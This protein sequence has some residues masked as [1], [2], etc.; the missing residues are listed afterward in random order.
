MA[1][2]E[3]QLEQA[4]L[5]AGLVVDC[6]HANSGKDYRRQPPV[7]QN[8]TNQILE[9]NQSIIGIM[10][11]SH[12]KDGNQPS[13]GKTKADLEYGVSITDGCISWETTEKLLHEI[14]EK[15]ITVLPLRLNKFLQ[16]S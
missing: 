7:A 16:A 3:A 1:D 2:C 12:L 5:S 8:V 6:S 13:E 4:G 9:G 15:L 10:L 14:R 11:E